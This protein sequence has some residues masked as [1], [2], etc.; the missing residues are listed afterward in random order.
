MGKYEEPPGEG[1]QKEW[2]KKKERQQQRA[3]RERVRGRDEET[4]NK[5]DDAP[6]DGSPQASAAT[7]NYT[8]KD[9]SGRGGGCCSLKHQDWLIILS[10]KSRIQQGVAR[11]P[12]DTR[13]HHRLSKAAA[14]IIRP[15]VKQLTSTHTHTQAS[16]VAKANELIHQCVSLIKSDVGRKDAINE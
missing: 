12:S 2:G 9:R 5:W 7:W 13:I 15:P 6:H 3:R 8:T 4:D 16:G 14:S 1:E 11:L 10:E